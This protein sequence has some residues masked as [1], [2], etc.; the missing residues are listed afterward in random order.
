MKRFQQMRTLALLLLIAVLGSC[1]KSN[2]QGLNIPKDAVYAFHINGKSLSGKLT[3]EEIRKNPAWTEISNDTTIPAFAKKLLDNPENSGIDIKSD[4]SFF[5]ANDISGYYAG[6]TGAIKDAAKFELLATEL[7]NGGSESEKDGIKYISAYPACVGWTKDKFIFVSDAN[8]FAKAMNGF[9]DADKDSEKRDVGAACKALFALTAENSLGKNEKFST[10][11]KDNGDMHLWV[12]GEAALKN[13]PAMA[14]LSMT[15]LPKLYEGNISTVSFRFDD[16]KISMK[17]KWYMGKE[18]MAIIKKYE[19]GKVDK[20]M[21]KRLPAKDLPVVL[22]MNFKPEVI[23][24]MVKLTG[25]DGLLNMGLARQGFTMD[26]FISANKGDLLFAITDFSV[27]QDSVT[28]TV[29]GKT[30]S[31]SNSKPEISFLFSSAIKDKE[32]F[33]KLMRAGKKM[34]A[35][36]TYDSTDAGKAFASGNNDQYFV[37]GSNKTL[38]DA[39][40]SGTAANNTIIDQLGKTPMAGFANLQLLMKGVNP[41]TIED[42]TSKAMYQLSLQMWDKV[43]LSGGNIEDGAMVQ[44]MEVT[45]MDSKTN[46]LKQLNT[47]LS[48]IA[49]LQMERQKKR[50]A[51]YKM[52]AMLTDTPVAVKTAPLAPPPPPPAVRPGKK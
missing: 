23:K 33:S 44:D 40:L 14:L 10:L 20:D 45:L 49:Q 18:L 42:S 35:G 37:L 46:S 47:Y 21:L 22:A 39:F 25:M 31:F 15:S 51:E 3:W 52:P 43:V 48:G 17:G 36:D 13:N 26:D 32:A 34:F 4:L 41:D 5:M 27:K 29:D 11:V 28:Y 2:K 30:H 16:G 6:G 24:E 19:G 1:N 50:D 7:M 8:S 38:T 12:N 9:G